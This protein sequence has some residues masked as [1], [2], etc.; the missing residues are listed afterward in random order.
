MFLAL[1]DARSQTPKTFL[2][3]NSFTSIQAP[4]RLQHFGLEFFDG[5]N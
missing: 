1:A 5:R 3:V 4:N 2:A